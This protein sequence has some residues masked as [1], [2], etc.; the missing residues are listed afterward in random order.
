MHDDNK[1][2]WV[3]LPEKFD[4]GMYYV[5]YEYHDERG[6]GFS[7]RIFDDFDQA[8]NFYNDMIADGCAS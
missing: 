3:G 1:I 5:P 2:M 7:R 6:T 8:E 4:N